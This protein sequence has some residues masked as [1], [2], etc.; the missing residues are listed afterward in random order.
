M[1]VF[2][3]VKSAGFPPDEGA[4]PLHGVPHPARF[5]RLRFVAIS[6]GVGRNN[7]PYFF[8]SFRRVAGSSTM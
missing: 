2:S 7:P 8:L 5:P 4:L 6:E 3:Q 1:V